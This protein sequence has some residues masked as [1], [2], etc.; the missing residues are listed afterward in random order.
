MDARIETCRVNHRA[1]LSANATCK[2]EVQPLRIIGNVLGG[3]TR[4]SFTVH[5][6]QQSAFLRADCFLELAADFGQGSPD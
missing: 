5:S 1:A 6:A 2:F 4:T 3:A